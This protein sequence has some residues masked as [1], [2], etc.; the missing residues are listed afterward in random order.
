MQLLQQVLSASDMDA[1]EE[2]LPGEG[3]RSVHKI[4]LHLQNFNFNEIN[5]GKI[6]KLKF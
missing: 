6:K 5:N 1:D 3:G 4:L 2:K